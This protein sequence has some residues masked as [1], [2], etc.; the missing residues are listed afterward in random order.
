[1]KIINLLPKSRQEELGYELILKKLYFVVWLSVFS[2]VLV[3]GVQFLAQLFLKR[4]LSYV[5]KQIESTK[6]QINKKENG[7][8]KLK[9]NE[10]NNFIADYKVLSQVSP[11]W[12]K[13]LKTFAVIPPDGVK[14]QTLQVNDETK[15]VV[16]SGYSP[17]RDLV[18]EFY[19]RLSKDS[20]KF[21][22]VERFFENI[23][24]PTDLNFHINFSVKEEVLR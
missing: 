17:T 10:I 3:F 21:Y 23:S 4:E 6:K 9:V 5:A 11:K 22:N 8:V 15:N 13:F 7:E 19:D 24:K 2:F 20:S 16:I 18:L 1:M 12:S 14:I